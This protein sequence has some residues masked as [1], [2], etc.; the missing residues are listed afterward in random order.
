MN[1]EVEKK[2]VF[3][4]INKIDRILAKLTINKRR[5]KQIKSERKRGNILFWLRDQM[6]HGTKCLMD[7]LN[8]TECWLAKNEHQSFL[9]S[10]KKKKKKKRRRRRRREEILSVAFYETSITLNTKARWYYKR[11]KLQINIPDKH[12][13]KNPQQNTSN[14]WI[15]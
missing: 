5:L 2:W 8:R 6:S 7:V 11:R 4:K 1:Q 10:S 15:Q 13:C 12:R 9:N 14:N 3:F